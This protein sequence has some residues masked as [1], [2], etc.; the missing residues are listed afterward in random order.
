M[1]PF[2]RHTNNITSSRTRQ[3]N[4]IDIAMPAITPV[5]N[6]GPFSAKKSKLNKLLS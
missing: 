2:F 6:I 3:T 5:D 1:I 4:I